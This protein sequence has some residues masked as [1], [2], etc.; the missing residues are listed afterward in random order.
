MRFGAGGIMARGV[1]NSTFEHNRFVGLENGLVPGAANDGKAGPRLIHAIYLNNA[2]AGNTVR[3]NH[4][5][6]VSGDPVRISNASHNNRVINNTSDN[7]GAKALVSD[8]Y[9][10]SNPNNPQE[11]SDGTVMRGNRIGA[12]YGRRRI[13]KR[14]HRKES[15]GTRPDLTV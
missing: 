8:W 10:T 2:S 7:A 6:D 12:G 14:F 4:F 9:N 3:G 13:P 5:E 15:R 11:R 1:R